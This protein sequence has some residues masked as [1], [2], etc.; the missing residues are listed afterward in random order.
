MTGTTAE[1]TATAAAATTEAQSESAWDRRI[2]LAFRV[3]A[4]T[5]ACTWVAMLTAMLFKYVINGYAFGVTVAG[6]IHGSVWLAFVAVC[7]VAAIRFRW[8]PWIALTGLIMSGLPFLTI[9]FDIWM[10]RTGRLRA[11]Q[12]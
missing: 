2:R 5:E 11:R 10:K 7:L 3:V 4:R 12:Q 8:K 9:P 1:T 6:W